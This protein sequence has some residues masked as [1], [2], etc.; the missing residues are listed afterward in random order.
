MGNAVK[1]N[2]VKRRIRFL[3]KK[4]YSESLISKKDFVIVAKKGIL[5]EKFD[6]LYEELKLLLKKI[7][8]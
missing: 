1:R 6:I 5:N 4:S 3:I 8:N 2:Y 7:K